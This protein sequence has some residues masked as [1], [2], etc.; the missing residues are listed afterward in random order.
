[1]WQRRRG[2]GAL[3]LDDCV[4]HS[5]VVCIGSVVWC[6]FIMCSVVPMKCQDMYPT[7]RV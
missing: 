1:M 3:T 2:S 4:L 6:F 7:E 5:T